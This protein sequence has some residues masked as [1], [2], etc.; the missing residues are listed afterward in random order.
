MYSEHAASLLCRE[1][2]SIYELARVPPP[3]TPFSTPALLR[4]PLARGTLSP[5]L[6]DIGSLGTQYNRLSTRVDGS[7]A[8]R[9]WEE[10]DT[11]LLSAMPYD[12]SRSLCSMPRQGWRETTSKI[13]LENISS[14]SSL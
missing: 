13:P 9:V 3:P 8:S 11:S 10:E 14:P 7:V 4:P 12:D 5:T 2:A 1:V 6:C